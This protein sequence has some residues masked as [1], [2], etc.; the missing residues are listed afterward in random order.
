VCLF[1]NQLRCGRFIQIYINRS[2]IMSRL[3]LETALQNGSL[4]SMTH[5]FCQRGEK[6][7]DRFHYQN[8][9]SNLYCTSGLD[10]F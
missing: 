6:V 2:L 10:N 1:W 4:S 3:F 7:D 8:L 5:D 9:H